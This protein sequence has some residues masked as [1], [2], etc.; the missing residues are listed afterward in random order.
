[1]ESAVLIGMAKPSLL[2]SWRKPWPA[3]AAVFIPTTL[4]AAF[5]SG[6][7]ESPGSRAALVSIRPVRRSLPPAS[8]LTVIAWARPVT[9]PVVVVSAPVPLAL[10]VAETVWPTLTVDELPI[11]MVLRFDAPVAWS[12]RH[13][14][15][16]VVADNLRG[17][18]ATGARER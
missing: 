15:G 18:A 14:V 9:A 10:P 13:V 6:P 3:E 12:T 1:M 2:A 7:P 5:R 4:P 16:H 11:E 8:S 17:I